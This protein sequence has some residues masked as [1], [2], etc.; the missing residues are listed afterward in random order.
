MQTDRDYIERNP[1]KYSNEMRI[2]VLKHKLEKRGEV[3]KRQ[4]A[5]IDRLK[6]LCS[7]D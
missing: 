2:I 3:I 5:E 1:L 7:E 4:Q 6:S